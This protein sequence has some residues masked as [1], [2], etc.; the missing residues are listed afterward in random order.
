MAK[1][2][3]V[4]VG[5]GLAGLTAGCYALTSGYRT[6]VV[7][8]NIALG[9]VCTAWQ[10]GPY[11]VDGCIHWL[12][13]GPFMGLYDELA[14]TK[15]VE[16][17]TLESWQTYRHERDGVS[18]AF[19]RDLDALVADLTRISPQDRAELERLRSGARDILLASPPLDA[20]ETLSWRE[21]WRPLWDARG[22]IGTFVHFR[23]S[24]GTWAAE[25][26]VSPRLRRIFTTIMPPSA[27]TFFLLMVLGYLERGY[28][29]RPVGGTAAFRDAIEQRYRALG[30][31][32]QMPATVD[33][34]LV[35]DRQVEG[36][37]LAD[38]TIID[39]DVVISTAS[40]PETVLRLLGARYEPE[41]TRNRLERWKLFPPIVLA[42]FGVE[43]PYDKHPSL[44]T[45]DGIA[46]VTIGG[47]ENDHAT[48]RVLNDDPCF[49]PAGHTVVQAIF[50][51]D[52]DHWATRGTR[53]H[54][55]KEAVADEILGTLEPLFPEIRPAVRETDIVTPLT[56]WNMA[57]S[58]R[59]AYEGWIPTGESWS[60]HIEKKLPGLHGFYMAG[61]WVEP[62]GGVPMAVM[63]GRQAI[64]L[65]CADDEQPFV[66]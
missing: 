54:A 5:G 56:Y 50:Q 49:A 6:T 48:I 27:P 2:H 3:V 47:H 28:L 29:S 63:S 40:A 57:R 4:I 10:R 15:E 12:T 45:L 17:R 19:T 8:H 38:G 51:T 7:E 36:V 31:S 25:Q 61:Q 1:R 66:R 34:I 46:P 32:V 59:G 18:V 41:P 62:G 21:R 52:Y 22:A 23:K 11:L 65:L 13:G 37:R 55:E 53:Y 14:V 39:A 64:Q 26:L 24:V 58:W 16:L 43:R 60:T 42:S 30:G 44:M 20:R 35:R 33:E 9:G